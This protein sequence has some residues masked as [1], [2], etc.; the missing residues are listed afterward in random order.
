MIFVISKPELTCYLWV[1][2]SVSMFFETFCNKIIRWSYC[3]G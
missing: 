2:F 1:C 3:S